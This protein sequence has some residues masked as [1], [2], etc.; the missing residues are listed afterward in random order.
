MKK[1]CFLLLILIILLSSCRRETVIN[2]PVPS[3]TSVSTAKEKPL[4]L[5]CIPIESELKLIEGWQLLADY[6]TDQTGI[7]VEIDTK[8]SYEDIINGLKNGEVDMAYLGAL[9]YIKAHEVAGVIPIVQPNFITEKEPTYRSCIIV[10]KD[11]GIKKFADL[12]GKKF[13][14]TDKDST[15]GYLI[16]V[17]MMAGSGI[18]NL[19]FFSSY[20][21]TGDHEAAFLAVY[22]GYVDGGAVYS[23]LFLDN[24]DPRLKDIIIIKKSEPIPTG[25]IVIRKEIAPEKMELI[26]K[27][28]MSVGDNKET[29]EIR[30]LIKTSH[31]CETSDKDYDVIRKATEVFREMRLD[32]K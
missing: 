10:R 3:P 8:K 12:K 1:I 16:P 19:K 26:K 23:R 17:S 32:K 29:E 14:F 21:F 25:P 20:L 5:S 31:Y 28:Y 2:T 11:S 15:S 4:V 9:S 6:I 27:A 13:A 30:K 7:P 18:K 22:N 24:K